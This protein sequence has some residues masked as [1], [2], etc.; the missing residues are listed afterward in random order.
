MYKFPFLMEMFYW[1]VTYGIYR[2]T[3]IL[4][5]ELFS[6]DIWDIAQENGLRILAFQQFSA[7]RW[8]FPL[9]E[10]DVQHWFMENHTELLTLFNK[11]YALLHIPLSVYFIGWYYY[12][13]PTHD[14]FAVV[15]RTVTLCN[16]MAFAVFTLYPCMPPRLL[17]KEYGFIDTVRR[18]DAESV[19]MSGKFV[20]H[21]A[22]MPSMHFGYAFMIGATCWYHAGVFKCMGFGYVNRSGRLWKVALVSAG[23]VYP[24]GV[25]TIIVATANHVSQF[26]L[27][28]AVGKLTVFFSVLARCRGGC[29]HSRAGFALQPGVFGVSPS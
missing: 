8:A 21:L 16:L 29:A 10:I 1:V 19:W 25:M 5:Q 12:A 24:L 6:D 22:A 15:R 11:C 2:A 7:F 9:Q 27:A 18:D 13:A 17:P 28:R 4:S 3:H 20:N 26:W 14:H 23:A